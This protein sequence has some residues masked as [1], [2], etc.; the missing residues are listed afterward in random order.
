MKSFSLFFTAILCLIFSLVSPALIKGNPRF[1]IPGGLVAE[2]HVIQNR[3]FVNLAPMRLDCKT[4]SL[5]FAK[6]KK[7]AMEMATNLP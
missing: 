1:G 3:S 4:D 2:L 5:A 6:L 7:P